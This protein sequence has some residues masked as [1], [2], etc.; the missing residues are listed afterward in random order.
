VEKR[1]LSGAELHPSRT[2][3]RHGLMVTAESVWPVR[4]GPGCPDKEGNSCHAHTLDPTDSDTYP[5]STESRTWGAFSC[6][7]ALGARV[8]GGRPW[9]QVPATRLRP[10]SH[11]QKM[12]PQ[13]APGPQLL[14]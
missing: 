7:T 10:R 11:G 13:P 12:A 6:T 14:Q 4:G 3:T 9:Q 5:G 2:V 1:R 8:A